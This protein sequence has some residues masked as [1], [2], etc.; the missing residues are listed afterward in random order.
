M[1]IRNQN[2]TTTE[3]HLVLNLNEPYRGAWKTYNYPVR[4]EGL[5]ISPESI[6]EAKRIG[7]KILVKVKKYGEYEISPKKAEKFIPRYRFVARDKK[8]LAVI[9][10][11]EFTRIP[12]KQE[13]V[14]ERPSVNQMAFL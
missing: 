5:G 10:R 13:V 1:N 9:P 14:G 2:W 12:D 7:K 11:V 3:T 4:C 6:R 8:T